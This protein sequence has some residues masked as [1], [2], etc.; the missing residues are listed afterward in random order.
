MPLVTV[1]LEE[2]E[3]LSTEALMVAR[4]FCGDLSREK[5]RAAMD[6]YWAFAKAHPSDP[7]AWELLMVREM[8]VNELARRDVQGSGFDSR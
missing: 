5:I 4:P 6:E 3:M 8:L 2:A 7:L 1:L